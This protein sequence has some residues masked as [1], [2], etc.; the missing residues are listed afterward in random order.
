MYARKRLR[1]FDEKMAARI[2]L[3]FGKIQE[4]EE[5]AERYGAGWML[6][7]NIVMMM[8]EWSK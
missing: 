6:D 8:S 4:I 3:F 2:N 7:Q 1:A 5:D